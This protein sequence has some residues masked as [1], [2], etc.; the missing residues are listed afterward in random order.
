MV[1]LQQNVKC[2]LFYI[3]YTTFVKLINFYVR[4]M[5]G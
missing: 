2:L 1:S 4:R 5:G 3:I